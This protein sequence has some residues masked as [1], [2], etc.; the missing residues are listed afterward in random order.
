MAPGVARYDGIVRQP[1]L[2]RNGGVQPAWIGRWT[3]GKVAVSV[4]SGCCCKCFS[5]LAGG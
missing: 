4:A 1:F 5:C 2:S 3:I